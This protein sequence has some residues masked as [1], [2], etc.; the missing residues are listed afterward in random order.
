MSLYTLL[1]SANKTHKQSTSTLSIKNPKVGQDGIYQIYD[2]AGNT[3]PAWV[4]MTTDGGYW[5]QVLR[6]STPLA[7]GNMSPMNKQ[8]VKGQAISGFSAVPGSYP[9]I[10]A[11]KIGANPANE[12]LFQNEHAQWKTLYGNWQRGNLFPAGTTSIQPGVPIPVVTSIGN[13]NFWGAR[14]GWNLVTDMTSL[15]FSFWTQAG[16]GGPCG[17]SGV[18]GNNKCCPMA[19]NGAYSSHCDYTNLKRAYLRASNYPKK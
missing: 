16:A 7:A 11:G 19:D 3:F 17:G 5:I 2:D 10:P 12:F 8:L 15:Q 4:D 9:S 13:K 14:G 6:W 18:V 1:I